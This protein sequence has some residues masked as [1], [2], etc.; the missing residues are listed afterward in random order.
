MNKENAIAIF[1]YNRPDKTEGLLKSLRKNNNFKKFKYYIFSDG[2]K[3]NSEINLIEDT[4]KIIKNF[5]VNIDYNII[6]NNSNIGLS[7]SIIKGVSYVLKRHK[8][9]IV[10]EDDLILSNNFLEYMTVSIKE[11]VDNKKVFS[12]SSHMYNSKEIHSMKKF[13][14]LKSI[15]SWGWATWDD[16]WSEFTEFLKKNDK[17]NL[18]KKEIYSFNLENSYPF[19]K[20]LRKTLKEKVDSWAIKWYLFVFLR[21]GLSL[22][23]YQT[24]VLNKGFDGSGTNT[25][26][27]SKNHFISDNIVLDFPDKVEMNDKAYFFYKK[28][29][30]KNLNIPIHKK[31]FYRILSILNK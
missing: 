21:K 20:I 2:H 15:N 9:I 31:I 25:I 5:F 24:L 28:L 3:R 17:V 1:I 8:N 29:I 11:Y 30:K 19:Y 14:F 6:E 18:S 23:P 26:L 16:R 27:K 4:R 22:Y 10:L 7:K 12:I 13:F